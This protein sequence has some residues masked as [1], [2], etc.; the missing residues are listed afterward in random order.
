VI[1]AVAID[2]E[3]PSGRKGEGWYTLDCMW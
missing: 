2:E 1:A 3:Q